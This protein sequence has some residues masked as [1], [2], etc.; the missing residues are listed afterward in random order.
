[1]PFCIKMFDLLGGRGLRNELAISVILPEDGSRQLMNRIAVVDNNQR[2]S[3]DSG[4][5][6]VKTTLGPNSA[7]APTNIS[8]TLVSSSPSLFGR[9]TWLC[10][11]INMTFE[12]RGQRQ[13][14]IYDPDIHHD[15]SSLP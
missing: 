13:V 14:C 10:C 5:G 3:C 9:R 7:R 15:T 11:N 2:K 8:L 1:M 4:H 12:A 6:Q